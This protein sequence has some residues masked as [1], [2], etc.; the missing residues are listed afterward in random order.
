MQRKEI[1]DLDLLIERCLSAFIASGTL[2]LSLDR[3]AKEVRTSKRML[4]HY[5]GSREMIEQKALALLEDRLR[6]MFREER[7]PPGVS[8]ETVVAAL[9]AQS[10]SPESRGAL[11]VIMDVSRRGWS[12]SE[13]AK[14]FYREQQRLWVDMLLKYLPDALAVEGLLQLFQGAIL[15]YLVT[16]DREQGK[17]ALD[18]MILRTCPKTCTAGYGA[19]SR[20][21]F[22]SHP[23]ND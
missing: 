10:T 5:F 2:D 14:A 9:W 20:D 4:I 7:F 12:G 15:V 22:P 1:R 23:E 16:G 11:Q 13:R 17:R 8:L 18:R 19:S 21:A 3:L 6:D